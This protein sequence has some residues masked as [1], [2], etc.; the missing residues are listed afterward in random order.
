MQMETKREVV[1]GF[2][3]ETSGG[4]LVFDQH[5]TDVEHLKSKATHDTQPLYRCR[6]YVKEL[7]PKEW[8]NKPGKIYIDRQVTETG[9]V[10]AVQISFVPSG[11]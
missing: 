4:Q 5:S 7:L 3:Y 6:K 2:I 9:E 8:L 1:E 10:M 11:G